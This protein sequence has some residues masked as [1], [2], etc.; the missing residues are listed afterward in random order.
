M[1]DPTGIGEAEVTER[2]TAVPQKEEPRGRS[3]AFFTEI[4]WVLAVSE[5][6][7]VGH[8][9]VINRQVQNNGNNF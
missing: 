6:D 1:S 3:A 5:L 9:W 7:R 8:N 2:H 4:P